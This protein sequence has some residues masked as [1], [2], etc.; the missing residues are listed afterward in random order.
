MKFFGKIKF[1]NGI[2]VTIL[3]VI[4][5]ALYLNMTMS[6]ARSF[7]A[8]IA[9]DTQ[10]VGSSFAGQV[11]DVEV[12]EGD[13]V[14]KGQVLATVSSPELLGQLS[15]GQ[16]K[17]KDLGVS[18]DKSQNIEVTAPSDGMVSK[19]DAT[20]GASVPAGAPIVELNAVG[21]LY[22][23]A[24]YHLNPPD[25][26][27]IKTGNMITVTLPDNSTLKAKIFAI[28][29]TQNG[30][31]VD[32]IVKARLQGANMDNFRFAVGTPVQAEM[33]FSD[34]LWYETLLDFAKKLFQPGTN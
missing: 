27:R 24:S 33:R 15:T 31:A 12:N 2:V 32:T 9:A 1:L 22:V 20:P 28:N 6:V 3:I 30:S 18:L 26:A 23:I 8:Q 34:K 16:V 19:L 7:K 10:N 5:L 11:V 29:L 25:Y 13:K 21:S 4:M 14:K 17:S